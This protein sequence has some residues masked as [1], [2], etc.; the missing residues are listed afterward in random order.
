MVVV[1]PVPGSL[2]LIMLIAGVALA[3]AG[4]LI[5]RFTGKRRAN[6]LMWFGIAFAGLCG[7]GFLL[8]A[9]TGG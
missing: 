5:H 7:I 9:I 3:I 8:G 6:N 4:G 1:V 2:L